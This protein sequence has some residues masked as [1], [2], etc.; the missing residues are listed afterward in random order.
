[1]KNLI[2]ISTMLMVIIAMVFS[3]CTK[4]FEDYSLNPNAPISVPPYLILRGVLNGLP[5]YPNSDEE[6][7]SQFTCRNYTYYPKLRIRKIEKISFNSP[8][9]ELGV[10]KYYGLA[11]AQNLKNC[12]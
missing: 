1:M 6:R 2:K 3:S 8:Q 9:L 12:F 10:Y 4:Q 7:W 11:L 5:V